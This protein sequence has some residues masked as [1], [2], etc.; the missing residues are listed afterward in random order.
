MAIIVK[1]SVSGCTVDKYEAV[2]RELDAIG[3]T[4]SPPGQLFHVAYGTRDNVQVIDV[5]DAPQSLENFGKSLGPILAKY[6]IAATSEVSE[7][8]NILGPTAV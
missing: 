2:L 7:V 5:F 1:F 6:G 4:A 8:F 3:V